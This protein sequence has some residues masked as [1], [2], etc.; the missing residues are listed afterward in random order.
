MLNADYFEVTILFQ[1]Y[2]V[3]HAFTNP[4]LN[5]HIL[6]HDCK[7]DRIMMKDKKITCIVDKCNHL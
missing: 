5:L 3:D 4:N 2:R 7:G 6:L 1:N